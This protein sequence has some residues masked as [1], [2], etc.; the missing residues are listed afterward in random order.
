MSKIWEALKRAESERESL[1]EEALAQVGPLSATQRAAVQALLG[2]EGIPAACSA[3]GVSE[4]T[5]QVWLRDPAFV[6]AYH[7]VSRARRLDAGRAP[8]RRGSRR[9]S[10]ALR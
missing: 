8:S 1:P 6:A 5:M 2:N 10:R 7:A 4:P 3:C 9:L